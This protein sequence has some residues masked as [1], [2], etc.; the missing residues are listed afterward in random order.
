MSKSPKGSKK[1]FFGD[2][3]IKSI[4]IK[5]VTL[6]KKKFNSLEV[7][8]LVGK[9]WLARQVLYKFQSDH[10]TYMKDTRELEEMQRELDQLTPGTPEYRSAD[11]EMIKA[12]ERFTK[13]HSN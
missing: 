4:L 9:A 1:G 8:K 7:F 10:K 6:P 3:T 5:L 11:K 13:R 2:V 12:L